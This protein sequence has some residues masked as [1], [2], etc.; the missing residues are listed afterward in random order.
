[1]SAVLKVQPTCGIDESFWRRNAKCLGSLR[2]ALVAWHQVQ[3]SLSKL[4]VH[5]RCLLID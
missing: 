1:M 4:S 5:G 2:A 3:V